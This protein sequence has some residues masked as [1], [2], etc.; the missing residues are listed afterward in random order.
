VSTILQPH[1]FGN[2]NWN[3]LDGLICGQSETTTFVNNLNYN[4]LRYAIIPAPLSDSSSSTKRQNDEEEKI[5]SFLKFRNVVL[6]FG[7]VKPSPSSAHLHSNSGNDSAS[8]VDRSDTPVI[9]REN[10]LESPSTDR[11]D[12]HHPS[13]HSLEQQQ[14]HSLLTSSSMSNLSGGSVSGGHPTLSSAVHS[15]STYNLSSQS[16]PIGIL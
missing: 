8:D 9:S 13:S 5:S 16:P 7:V 2:Y 1:Q 11:Q 4:R 14:Q 3:M 6:S 10:M 15:I 12:H